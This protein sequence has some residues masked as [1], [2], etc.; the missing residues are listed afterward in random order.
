MICSNGCIDT[1]SPTKISDGVLK[2]PLL[3]EK[4]R[5]LKKNHFFTGVYSRAMNQTG[6][7]ATDVCFCARQL[8]LDSNKRKPN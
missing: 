6:S 1:V 5:R 2:Q 8:C 7:D 4:E 3:L